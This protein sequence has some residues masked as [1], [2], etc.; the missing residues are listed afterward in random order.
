[1]D[2]IKA[3]A[4]GLLELSLQMNSSGVRP[5]RA[6]P[7]G[8]DVGAYEVS[9]VLPE[10]VMAVVVIGLYRCVLDAAVH[11]LCIARRIASVVAALP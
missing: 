2:R 5:F 7:S 10:L 11:P 1:M 9:Q 8:E 4:F 3:E 6:L